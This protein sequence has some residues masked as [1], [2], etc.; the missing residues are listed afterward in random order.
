MRSNAYR[1]FF[2][3]IAMTV[4]GAA[5]AEAQTGN[6]H[7][8]G[9]KK[10]SVQVR[11][12]PQGTS[13][14]H[15]KSDTSLL[16][17]EPHYVL[18]MAYRENVATFAK[19]LRDQASAGSLSSDF[20]RAAASEISRGIDDANEHY[21]EHLKT[22]GDEMRAKMAPMIKEID[23]RSS[24]LKDAF[25]ILEKHVGEYTLNSKQIATDSDVILKQLYDFP[26]M[27]QPE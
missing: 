25:R 21:G 1:T 22:M 16:I 26:K 3:V 6:N 10:R 17:N 27:H 15:S 12:K 9:D 19:A 5:Y 11:K 2:A 13:Q 7:Q 4:F 18:A 20:A 14:D 24:K 23:L 8:P